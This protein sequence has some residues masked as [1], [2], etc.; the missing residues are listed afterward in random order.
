MSK[1]PASNP[2]QKIAATGRG[3]ESAGVLGTEA[4]DEVLTVGLSFSRYFPAVRVN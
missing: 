3:G 2:P 4:G 1:I